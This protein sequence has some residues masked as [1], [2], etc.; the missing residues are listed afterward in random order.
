MLPL[1]FLLEPFSCLSP[2]APCS[3][4]FKVMLFVRHGLAPSHLAD[5]FKQCTSSRSLRSVFQFLFVVS[6]TRPINVWFLGHSPQTGE[7]LVSHCQAGSHLFSK[8]N[9]KSTFTPGLLTQF[10]S[11]MLL[12]LLYCL[13][14]CNHFV[15]ILRRIRR[16]KDNQITSVHLYFRT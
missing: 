11:C 3:V 15:M 10:E 12:L 8:C 9:L 1:I 13:I 16:Y 2:L 5:L 6:K 7:W 14:V 4:V